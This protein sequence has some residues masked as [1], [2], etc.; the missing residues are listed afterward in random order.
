MQIRLSD[1]S[2]DT[3]QVLAAIGALRLAVAQLAEL[4][5][6]LVSILELAQSIYDAQGSA[7]VDDDRRRQVSEAVQEAL[8]VLGVEHAHMLAAVR[9]RA[10]AQHE[11]PDDAGWSDAIGDDPPACTHARSRD[12]ASM[13]P[14]TYVCDDCGAVWQRRRVRCKACSHMQLAGA[15]ACAACGCTSLLFA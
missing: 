2:P 4:G 8:A 14:G 1:L 9:V 3:L 7:L 11:T 15:D 12:A 10:E 13:P 5:A 6:P